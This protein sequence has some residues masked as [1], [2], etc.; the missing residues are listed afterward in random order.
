MINGLLGIH[1]RI[2]KPAEK[3]IELMVSG[4]NPGI[5][6]F[7]LWYNDKVVATEKGLIF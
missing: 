4:W 7:T 3:E 1:K 5:Y 6:C 2:I